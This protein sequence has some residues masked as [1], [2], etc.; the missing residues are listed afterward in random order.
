MSDVRICVDAMGGDEPAEVV[1]AGIEAALEADRSLTVLVAG[2]EDVVVPFCDSHERAESLVAPDVI[3][4][5]DDPINAVMTKRKSSIVLGCRAV[6][7]GR[8]TAFSPAGRGAITAA[9]TA[10]SPRSRPSATAGRRP[11]APASQ[12]LYPT[13]AAV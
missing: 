4:M 12:M 6:K 1:L 7:K 8:P 3:T 13:A 10:T 2:P 5:E 9:G 11:F